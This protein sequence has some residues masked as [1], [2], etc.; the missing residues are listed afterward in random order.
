MWIPVG[1]V[2]VLALFVAMVATGP[3]RARKRAIREALQQARDRVAQNPRDLAAQTA[4]ARTEIE[5]AGNGV[6]ALEILNRVHGEAPY[7]WVEGDKPTR[8]LIGE[9]YV[10]M[11]QLDRAI[12][13]FQAFVD[14]IGNYDTQG[15]AERKWKL[16]THKVDAEQRIR[17]LK[18][19]DTHVHQPEQW[20]DSGS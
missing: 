19:G 6:G 11:A 17:L 12:E 3:A 8:M 4:L 18:R 16:E 7:H 5:L 1:V 2:L 15:D 10:A 14:G 20:G 13:A 9:A